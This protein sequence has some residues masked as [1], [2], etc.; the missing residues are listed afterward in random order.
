MREAVIDTNVLVYDTF[1]DSVYHE[2]AAQLLD[3]LDSWVIP[4]I[5]IYEL[6]W[7]LKG[8]SL[9]ARIVREK[10]LDYAGDERAVIA[11]EGVE[12]VRWALNALVE[13]GISVARF[14]DKVVLSVAVRRGVP[15][16]T[17]DARLRRQAERMGI[18]VLPETV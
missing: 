16:A 5:V 12:G 1:S 9:E 13:E 10:V 18:E 3:S 7:F 6:V 17:F 11:C 2:Q 4:L 8:F 15:L 14:N